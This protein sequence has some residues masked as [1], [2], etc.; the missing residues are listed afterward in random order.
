MASLRDPLSL[1]QPP[2][3]PYIVPS[4]VTD[5]MQVEDQY[6]SY[7]ADNLET[8]LIGHSTDTKW[9]NSLKHVIADTIL[10]GRFK[11]QDENTRSYRVVHHSTLTTGTRSHAEPTE[12]AESDSFQ[13]KRIFRV[14]L[15]IHTAL[16]FL[17]SSHVFSSDKQHWQQWL[18]LS[19]SMGLEFHPSAPNSL[20]AVSDIIY[21]VVTQSSRSALQTIDI[22]I[23]SITGVPCE[24]LLDIPAG[25]DETNSHTDTIT[26]F[27]YIVHTV[28]IHLIGDCYVKHVNP[29]NRWKA[30]HMLRLSFLQKILQTHGHHYFNLDA[31]YILSK[32]DMCH[33][34]AESG[35]ALR[36]A[37]SKICHTAPSSLTVALSTSVAGIPMTE[38]SYRH[39]EFD[40][41]TDDKSGRMWYLLK[42][43]W[44]DMQNEAESIHQYGEWTSFGTLGSKF[45]PHVLAD[46]VARD[47]QFD[48]RVATNSHGD[49]LFFVDHI[50]PWHRPKDLPVRYESHEELLYGT[51]QGYSFRVPARPWYRWSTKRK[52][53]KPDVSGSVDTTISSSDYRPIQKKF[54]VCSYKPRTLEA[55][56]NKPGRVLVKRKGIRGLGGRFIAATIL[57]LG[58]ISV[59][60]NIAGRDNWLEVAFDGAQVM[61]LVAGLILAIVY[62][63][64]GTLTSTLDWLSGFTE[65]TDDI[66]MTR[67]LGVSLEE[68]K[69]ACTYEKRFL[70]WLSEVNSSFCPAGKYG[71]IMFTEPF[72]MEAAA[73]YVKYC[74]VIDKEHGLW[75]LQGWAFRIEKRGDIGHMVRVPY[76]DRV[77]VDEREVLKFGHCSY[78]LCDKQSYPSVADLRFQNLVEAKSI[79]LRL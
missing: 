42:P 49:V 34:V 10:R 11:Y 50:G 40:L 45:L 25:I 36:V 71:T 15:A 60:L 43:D 59:V 23:T 37:N 69:M 24:F 67:T 17:S 31:F 72:D 14:Y 12:P 48:K 66:Q 64:N 9:P 77:Y 3:L 65:V 41:R 58:I 19:S 22:L 27:N 52:S 75:L 28:L 2:E 62:I 8:F 13:R 79:G 4:D 53:S 63:I 78:I 51:V 47:V 57:V 56:L 68:M 35:L 54:E 18:A 1:Q 16:Q 38:N 20:G 26:I 73:R 46:F 76:E 74:S 7:L 55:V 21:D 33:V 61:S 32:L 70:F 29:G 39:A 30:M 44:D 6:K 5:L